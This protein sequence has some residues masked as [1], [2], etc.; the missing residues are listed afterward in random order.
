MRKHLQHPIFKIIAEQAEAM[1]AEAFVVGGYVR[2]IFL[3]RES[4]DIDVELI[5]QKKWHT[6]FRI[7]FMSAILKTSAL[8]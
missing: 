5:W 4:K 2:D 7:E 3:K 1:D 8:P 6:I